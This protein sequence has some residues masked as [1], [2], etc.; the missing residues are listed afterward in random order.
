MNRYK[1]ELEKITVPKSTVEKLENRMANQRRKLSRRGMVL[2]ACLAV[3]CSLSVVTAARVY[4]GWSISEV[5]RFDKDEYLETHPYLTDETKE[6]AR[7]NDGNYEVYATAEYEAFAFEPDVLAYLMQRAFQEGQSVN[8]ASMAEMN[9]ALRTKLLDSAMLIPVEDEPLNVFVSPLDNKGSNLQ[10]LGAQNL[11]IEGCEDI[12]C[13]YG[14]DLR[15]CSGTDSGV[16][17]MLEEDTFAFSQME[18]ERL[19]VTAEVITIE[20]GKHV[21]VCFTKDGIPYQLSFHLR[22]TSDAERIDMD[23]I[24]LVMDSLQ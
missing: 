19:Q 16:G 12:F 11:L 18:L 8:Y 7:Q 21:M 24:K 6:R 15:T 5:V 4:S 9:E 3:L 13:R 23:V 1:V 17:I 22:E 10:L 2:T 20:G 14:F